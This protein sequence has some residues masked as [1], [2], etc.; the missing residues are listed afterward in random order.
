MSYLFY[1]LTDYLSGKNLL[2]VRNRSSE[3]IK[4]MLRRKQQFLLNAACLVHYQSVALADGLEANPSVVADGVDCIPPTWEDFMLV[5]GPHPDLTI[6]CN[7]HQT[8]RFLVFRQNEGNTR[9]TRGPQLFLD[10]K[11]SPLSIC[12][13]RHLL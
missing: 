10:P 9:H 11:I 6:A 13:D 2:V 3:L 8:M 4:D 12:T 7:V 1:I 5:R